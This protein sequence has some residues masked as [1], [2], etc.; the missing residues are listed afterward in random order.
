MIYTQC[1]RFIGTALVYV[2]ENIFIVLKQVLIVQF[3]I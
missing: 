1:L 2:Y 3:L